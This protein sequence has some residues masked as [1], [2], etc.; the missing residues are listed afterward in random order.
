MARTNLMSDHCPPVRLY[1]MR[2]HGD[3]WRHR[4]HGAAN[5]SC[6]TIK[7]N[8]R[9]GGGK[10]ILSKVPR[11]ISIPPNLRPRV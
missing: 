11:F 4:R 8:R 2:E 7:R 1:S 10:K 5:R 6:G 9:G 3:E